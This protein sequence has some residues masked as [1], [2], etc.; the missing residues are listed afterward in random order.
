MP[1]SLSKS[2]LLEAEISKKNIVTEVSPHP[3]GL[4]TGLEAYTGVWGKQQAAHLIRR[5]MFGATKTEIKFLNSMTLSKAVDLLLQ[6]PPNPPQPVN[7]YNGVGEDKLNDKYIPFGAVYADNANRDIDVEFWKNV[8][9]KCWWF[10]NIIEQK[11]SIQEKM[12][13]FWQNH[14]PIQIF[15]IYDARYSYR[16]LNTLRQHAL[17]N[18]KS[19]MKAVTIDPA[20]LFFLNGNSNVKGT[21]D[22]NYGRELQELFCVGKGAGSKYTESDVKAAARVLTGWKSAYDKPNTYFDQW[23]HDS[24][25]K[26]FSAFYNNTIIKGVTGPNGGN[27][28]LDAM[29]NMMFATTECAKHVIRKL[30]RF[31]VYHT[32]DAQ[33]EA[34]IITPLAQLYQTANYEIKPVLA[35]LLKSAHFFDVLNRGAI[36]KTPLDFT[37]GMLREYNMAKPPKTDLKET[38]WVRSNMYWWIRDML[39]DIGDPPN[40]AGWPAWYQT[41]Q[42]DKYWISTTTLP[43]RG[44]LSDMMIYWGYENESKLIRYGIDEF[45]FTKTLDKPEDPNLLIEEVLSLFFSISVNAT[46]K[47]ELKKILLDNQAQDYYWT[48][49]WLDHINNPNDAMKKETVKWKLKSLYQHIMQMEEYQLM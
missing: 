41:P 25:D 48:N 44:S 7:D 1:K 29:L 12:M 38:F 24:G 8:S 40:V 45:A 10:N 14:V 30:Y 2:A 36:I 17:G 4:L 21:P 43:K 16:Y 9:L 20:M 31:F 27:T 19:M 32:I 3:R 6:T 35:Q 39:L 13:L 42:F 37:L 22:E 18:F 33:T 46:V 15:E 34:T 49:A 11:Y 28:E 5:T 47:Q 26:Q 23:Q